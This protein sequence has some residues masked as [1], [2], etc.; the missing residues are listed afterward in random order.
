[1]NEWVIVNQTS[2]GRG[3]R[4]P[5]VLHVARLH[6]ARRAARF[7]IRQPVGKEFRLPRCERCMAELVAEGRRALADAR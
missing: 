1:M 7:G 5:K 4:K 2:P 6:A 3:L